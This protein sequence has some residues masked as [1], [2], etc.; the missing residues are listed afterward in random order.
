[1]AL[2]AQEEAEYT[3]Q[4]YLERGGHILPPEEAK[5]ELSKILLEQISRFFLFDGE[6][7]QEY[8][9]LLHQDTDSGEK[10]SQAIERILGLSI[11][12][13]SRQSAKEALERAEKDVAKAAQNDQKTSEF[14]SDLVRL[15]KERS[16]YNSDIL[17]QKVDLEELKTLQLE[18]E[19]R[20]RRN[21]RMDSLMADRDRIKGEILRIEEQKKLTIEDLQKAMATGW[22]SLIQDRLIELS[23]QLRSR[24]TDIQAVVTLSAVLSD[25]ASGASDNCPT[26]MQEICP[27]ALEAIKN[28]L[29][30]R[31]DAN[32]DLSEELSNVRRRLHAINKQLKVSSPQVL[33][34]LWQKF[35][36]LETQLYEQSIEL[37]EVVAKI[38]SDAE[39][40]IRE[41]KRSYE[42]TVGEI[43]ALK[44]GIDASQKKLTENEVITQKLQTQLEKISGRGMSNEQRRRDIPRDLHELFCSAFDTYRNDLQKRVEQDASEFFRQ[45]TT[46]PDNAGLRI[47]DT[48]GLTIMHIDGSPIPVRSAGAEHVSVVR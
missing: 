28:Q 19:E 31:D 14:G 27:E 30:G 16:E 3:A 38:S 17:R 33:E 48:Y 29:K 20:M 32:V 44:G 12:T 47:N 15:N 22:S 41:L 26:C 10:I 43:A 7:L 42:S 40:E 1:M 35:D 46:E 4:Y 2:D 9:E 21:A 45:M 11:L 13:G 5:R 37:D 39:S 25:L 36:G 24:E 8:E 18:I 34:M 6:L 23:E